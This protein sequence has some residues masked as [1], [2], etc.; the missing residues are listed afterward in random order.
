MQFK[1]H[2]IITQTFFEVTAFELKKK[3]D[4]E[5]NTYVQKLSLPMP[6]WNIRR[7]EV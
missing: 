5:C 2:L 1:N 7:G 6:I 4:G 3:D